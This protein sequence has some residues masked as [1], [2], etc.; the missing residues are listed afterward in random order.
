MNE[1][2]QNASVVSRAAIPLFAE[3]GS[4]LLSVIIPTFNEVENV[5]IMVERLAACLQDVRW[6]VVFVDDDSSD[7]TL[8]VLRD[9]SR[10]DSRV[11]F[12]HRIGRRGLA[13]AVTEGMLATSSPYLAVI[14]CDLQH[15]E[16]QLPLMLGR[17]LSGACDLVVASRY[18]KRSFG[19]W[20]KRR[21]RMSQLGTF[22]AQSLLVIPLSDPMSGFF[23]LTREAFDACAHD[24]SARGYKILLD[25]VMSSK[26]VPRIEE[27]PYEFRPRVHGGSKLDSAT[28]F[29][30]LLL[31]L[32]KSV[33]KFIPTRFVLFSVVG[34]SGLVVNLIVLAL[35][36]KIGH[37][38]F[39][40]SETV[41]TI[42]AMTSNFF[43]NNVLTYRDKRLR[44]LIQLTKGLLSFYLFCAL[45]AIANVGIASVLFE[46][47]CSWWLSAIA[48]TLVGVVWNYAMSST[49]T[50]S[51]T[52]TNT[53]T[54]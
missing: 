50:W 43:V 6:E 37:V 5:E 49:F 48:G 15:D 31:L 11:R 32:D 21:L 42:A 19:D 27:I 17:L 10:R 16:T 29:E 54:K 4:S 53:R 8:D 46:K 44:G 13:S 35:M 23:C 22:V 24:L 45:G 38:G 52:W 34:G 47:H 39:A 28:V 41:A 33:G 7:G 25:I 36:F 2:S 1:L 26:V 30:Y 3:L 18:L 14:D 51:N 20:D 9:L 40:L 12:I